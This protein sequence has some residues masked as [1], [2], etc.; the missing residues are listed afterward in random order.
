MIAQNTAASKTRPMATRSAIGSLVGTSIEWYDYFLYGTAAAVVFGP[1][2]FPDV[3]PLIGLMAS[4][5]T[6][7]VGFLARPLGGFV[8][9]HVGDR[10]G[11]KAMLVASLLIMGIGTTLI[12][13]LPTFA[14]IGYWA[15]ALLLLLRILQG[16]GAGAEWGGAALMSVEHAPSNKRGFYGSF[17][18]IGVPVG[19][20]M[21][22]GAFALTRA[23]IGTSGFLDWGWRLPFLSSAI[24]IVVGFVIRMALQDPPKFQ[25]MKEQNEVSKN[26]IADVYRHEQ[27]NV[28][29]A[30]GMRVS[31]NAVYYLY[32]VFAISYVARSLG[33]D[34]NVTLVAVMIS[35]AVGIVSTP[36]W[37]ILSDR[38]GRRRIYMFGAIGGGLF[39][40]P[41]FLLADTGN[42]ALIVIAMLI[43]VNFFHDAMYGPQ[44]AYFSEL[45]STGVRYSGASISYSIGS[46]F[47]GGFSPLIATALLAAGGGSP[48]LI[49]VYFLILSAITASCAYLTKE[50]SRRDIDDDTT[51]ARKPARLRTETPT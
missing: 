51:I 9:G 8:A 39:M 35:S 22:T 42:P 5:G 11:R 34:S 38:I 14:Q 23:L 15:P 20:L 29:L 49:I 25:E 27:R 7:A 17:T 2:F 3:D 47:G 16:F 37:A 32:T 36:L 31:Q 1:L 41:F 46:V 28:W 12:G 48:W 43:G 40:A 50:T 4:F 26:P 33:S 21:A 10:V 19:M 30:T 24:L 45:F 44:A 6:F 18:Q 13:A